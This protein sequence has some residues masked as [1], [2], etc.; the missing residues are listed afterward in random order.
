MDIILMFEDTSDVNTG[1]EVLIKIANKTLLTI[2][3]NISALTND[4]FYSFQQN[5]SPSSSVF[6][7]GWAKPNSCNIQIKYDNTTKTLSGSITNLKYPFGIYV[8]YGN[9]PP[10]GSDLLLEGAGSFRKHTIQFQ[11]VK[12][13]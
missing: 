3:G 10:V 5:F 4:V 12:S 1:S 9:F 11:Y 13:L 7:P 6:S 8:P 2:T